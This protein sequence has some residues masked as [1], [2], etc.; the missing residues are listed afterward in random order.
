MFRLLQNVCWN[1]SANTFKLFLNDRKFPCFYT[2]SEGMNGV[3]F[4]RWIPA[5]DVKG[6]W[7]IYGNTRIR[8]AGIIFNGKS[9]EWHR[10]FI[11]LFNGETRAFPCFHVSVIRGIHKFRGVARRIK[12]CYLGPLM[13]KGIRMA[14]NIKQVF[15]PDRVASGNLNGEMNWRQ[16]NCLCSE[17]KCT[18]NN[19]ILVLRTVSYSQ[20][21]LFLPKTWKINPAKRQG[22][23]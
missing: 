13:D 14:W 8:S 22:W 9:Y 19:K 21:L 17:M 1:L 3:I 15:A 7:M 2:Q 5:V 12:V 4:W 20:V 23:L 6:V 11:L 10:K 16:S 18:K